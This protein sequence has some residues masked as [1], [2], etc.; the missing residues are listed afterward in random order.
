MAGSPVDPAID[1][2]DRAYDAVLASDDAALRKTMTPGV[3]W[4]AGAGP[5]GGARD[6]VGVDEVAKYLFWPD[7]V[8]D[9]GAI[10]ITSRAIGIR[11]GTNVYPASH[12]FVTTARN[13]PVRLTIRVQTAPLLIAEVTQT[14]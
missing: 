12:V 5:M 3:R 2:I 9:H 13:Y 4:H 1:L 10:A 6:Y 7:R 14:F 8:R 11:L